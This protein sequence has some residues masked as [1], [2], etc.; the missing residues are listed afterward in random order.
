MRTGFLTGAEIDELLAL[1]AVGEICGRAIG[2][3]GQVIRHGTNLRAMAIPLDDPA[4]PTRIG[5]AAGPLKVA[6]LAAALRGGWLSG[7]ITDE[8]TAAAILQ[9]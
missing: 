8:I 6:P 5:I 9:T 4:H 7:L 1:G 2:G 3:D